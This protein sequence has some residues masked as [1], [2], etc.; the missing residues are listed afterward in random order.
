MKAAL[1]SWPASPPTLDHIALEGEA[2]VV[3]LAFSDGLDVMFLGV[4]RRMDG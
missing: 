4:F 2:L 1:T 3:P